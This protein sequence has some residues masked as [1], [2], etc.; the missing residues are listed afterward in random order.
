[1][2]IYITQRFSSEK[3]LEVRYMDYILF[4]FF[5][6]NDKI[7]LHYWDWQNEDMCNTTGTNHSL[8]EIE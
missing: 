5:M 7:V 6:C 1:M 3:K 4:E 8:K 2:K